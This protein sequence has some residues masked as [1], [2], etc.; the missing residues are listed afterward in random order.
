LNGPIII[1]VGDREEFTGKFSK[2]TAVEA[3][4]GCLLIALNVL[5]MG[6]VSVC[7]GRL[8]KPRFG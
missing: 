2:I 1:L 5:I 4:R 7:S 3:F 8:Y 6:R